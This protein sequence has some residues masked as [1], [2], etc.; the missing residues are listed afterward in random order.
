MWLARH[1]RFSTEIWVMFAVWSKVSCTHWQSSCGFD[2]SVEYNCA[3]MYELVNS[4]E[5]NF[6]ASFLFLI[7]NFDTGS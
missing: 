7:F 2:C 3:C 4:I 5:W 6:R 1:D